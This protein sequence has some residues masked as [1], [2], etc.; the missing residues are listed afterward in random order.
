[1]QF[2]PISTLSPIKQFSPR[3]TLLSIIEL[4][5]KSQDLFELKSEFKIHEKE[6]RPADQKFYVSN[7]NKINNKLQWFPKTDLDIGLESFA[8]WLQEN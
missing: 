2:S 4:L 3:I 8:S 1:M 7:I 6:W 5:Q